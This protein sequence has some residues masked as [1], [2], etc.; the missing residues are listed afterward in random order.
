MF[1]SKCGKEV[2]NGQQFCPNCGN[3][4]STNARSKV[5]IDLWLVLSI[6]SVLL[7]ILSV[8]MAQSWGNTPLNQLDTEDTLPSALLGIAAIGISGFCF[9]NEKNQKANNK[10]NAKKFI[11]STIIFVGCL[12]MGVMFVFLPFFGSLS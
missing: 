6:V 11:I 1:C 5:M 7:L 2:Q 8:S 10:G 4:L 9:Y 3:D 12:I